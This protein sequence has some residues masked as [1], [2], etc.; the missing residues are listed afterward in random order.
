M[1]TAVIFHEDFRKYDLGPNH[2]LR[3]D[4]YNHLPEVFGNDAIAARKSN[5]TFIKPKP[6]ADEFIG[7]VHGEDYLRF[8]EMMNKSGGALTLDTPI[9]PG[10]YSIAKLFAGANI[11][12][13]RLIAEDLF[14]RVVVLGLGSHHA[15]YDFGG[16]FCMIND[17]AVMIEYLRNNY[18]IKRIMTIDYDAHCGEGTQDIYYHDPDVLCLDL[19]QDPMTL[20]PGK[21]FAYQV[22]LGKGKGYTV[23]IPLPQ[24]SSDEHFITA[25]NKICIPIATQFQ[26]EIII[27]NGGLDAHFADPLSQLNLSLEGY[28]RLMTSIVNLS[29]QLCDNKLI[30]IV[31]GGY[32][33]GAV[34]SG[35]VAMISAMIGIDKIEITEPVEPPE[36]S[37]VAEKQAMEMIRNVKRIQKTYWDLEIQ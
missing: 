36:H 26:P 7:A 19:H 34:P 30:L 10:L 21:G 32:G 18:N 12:A 16:G 28:F 15:G 4:R 27:A 22:G 11:L 31:G 1:K 6:A 13:G 33:L 17:I 14:R 8:I 29:Q 9:P 20:F 35:W 23:N 24:G 2:P 25:F 3:G 37:E 5:I